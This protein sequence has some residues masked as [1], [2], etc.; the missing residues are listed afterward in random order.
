MAQL[1]SSDLSK[2]RRHQVMREYICVTQD[3]WLKGSA[4]TNAYIRTTMIASVVIRF[5]A[6]FDC[7]GVKHDWKLCMRFGMRIHETQA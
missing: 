4:L 5:I 3:S 1:L 6:L 7:L 2:S